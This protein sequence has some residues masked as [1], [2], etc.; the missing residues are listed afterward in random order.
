MVRGLIL[1]YDLVCKYMV[2]RRNQYIL[3]RWEDCV[4][5][6]VKKIGEEEDRKKKTR[7]RGGWK[8]LPE[9]AVTKLLAAPHP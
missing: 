9:E 8:R 5:R 2:Y 7:D 4:K 3:M 1:I 6:D